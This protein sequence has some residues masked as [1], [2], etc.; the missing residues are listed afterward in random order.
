MLIFEQLCTGLEVEILPFGLCE[1]RRDAAFSIKEEDKCSI[2]YVL[3]GEGFALSVTGEK[4]T[5]FPHSVMIVPPGSQLSITTDVSNLA[6]FADPRCKSLANNWDHMTVGDCAPGLTLACGHVNAT[7]FQM[8]NLFEFLREPIIESVAHE[9]AFRSSFRSFLDELSDPKPGTSVLAEMLMKQCL[10]ALLRNQFERTGECFAPW[11]A[12]LGDE[13]LG[14]A[15]SL[16]LDDPQKNHTLESLG[17]HVGLSRTVFSERFKKAFNR[18][19]IDFLK[20]IRLRR[21]AQLLTTTNLPVKR[22]AYRV[23]FE[24][25]SYFSRS[26]KGFF[27]ID[28]AGFRANHIVYLLNPDLQRRGF[29]QFVRRLASNREN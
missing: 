19:A 16:M 12:A 7:Y 28:P 6:N 20:E 13:S 2:H 22:I 23:G 5:L 4:H 25:R 14:R 1:I 17:D 9:K 24:S 29:L 10:I 26:F 15:L 11:L 8:V 27:G 3:A 21:A 18:T